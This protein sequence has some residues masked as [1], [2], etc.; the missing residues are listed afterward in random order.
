MQRPGFTGQDRSPL[1]LDLVAEST[2]G[3]ALLLGEVKWTAAPAR[4]YPW[5]ALQRKAENLALREGKQVFL[6]VWTPTG[7]GRFGRG[8]GHFG[9]QE[10]LQA[11]R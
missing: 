3:S 11:L 8:V 2:D 6:G 4:R 10:V 9:P 7:P 1:E 5:V